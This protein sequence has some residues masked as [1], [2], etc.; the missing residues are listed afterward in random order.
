MARKNSKQA[1]IDGMSQFKQRS[2]KRRNS[3]NKRKDGKDWTYYM[4]KKLK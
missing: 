1:R 4:L 3:A 2:Y